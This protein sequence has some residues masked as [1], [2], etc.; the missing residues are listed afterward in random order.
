VHE[1]IIKKATGAVDREVMRGE[2]TGGQGIYS[3]GSWGRSKDYW[4]KTSSERALYGA[5]R[6]LGVKPEK[7][8]IYRSAN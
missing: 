3:V 4:S 2:D 6:V 5:A 7:T 1:D 8:E